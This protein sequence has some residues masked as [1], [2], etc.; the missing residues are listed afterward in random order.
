MAR[1]SHQALLLFE[2][3]ALRGETEWMPYGPGQSKVA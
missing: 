3:G 1:S 2:Q